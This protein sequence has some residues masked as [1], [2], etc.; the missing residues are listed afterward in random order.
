M[1]YEGPRGRAAD[2]PVSGDGLKTVG[3][4]S[5]GR[6]LRLGAG[7]RS[8]GGPDR[9]ARVGGEHLYGA[10]RARRSQHGGTGEQ[11]PAPREELILI[12]E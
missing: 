9:G 11:R 12:H 4:G 8:G 10:G 7:G 1:P 6:A 2:R 3:G 5:Q